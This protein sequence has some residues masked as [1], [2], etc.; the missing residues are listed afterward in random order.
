MIR[1]ATPGIVLATACAVVWL[2]VGPLVAAHPSTRQGPAGP[3]GPAATPSA[4]PTSLGDTEFW[5]IV[6]EFS[7]PNGFFDSDNLLSNETT[8]Q[9]V[10]P[11]LTTTVKPGGAYLGVGPEQNF[12]YILAVKPGVAFVTDIR[13]GNLQVHLLYKALFELAADRSEFVSLLFSRARPAGLKSDAS[14]DALMDAYERAAPS[15]VLFRRNLAAVR[16]WLIEHHHFP[17]SKDDLDG[18]EYVYSSFYAAG[19]V[20]SYNSSRPQRS[21]YPTYSELQRETDGQQPRGYL[22][23]EANFTALK[24]FEERNL[25]VPLVG[26]FAGTKT[27]R[28]VAAYLRQHGA[29]VAAFYTS[30]VENYLF[31]SGSWGRFAKNV[32]ALPLDASSTFIRACFDSCPSVPG[33]R[34]TTLLDPMASLIRDF[35]AGKIR[36]YYDVLG[37]GR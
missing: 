15:E 19:P 27:L 32:E 35:N 22:A 8:F 23:S 34:S 6:S 31:Q 5:R 14:V 3:A 16:T 29:I 13:R 21:R 7:E 36:G 10:I 4:L 1:R 18:I 26:D 17:L 12:A 37:H 28:A 9:Y 11:R 2:V 20:L 25:I 33:S 30:N 24:R